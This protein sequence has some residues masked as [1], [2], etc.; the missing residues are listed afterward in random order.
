MINV[1]MGF[2]QVVIMSIFKTMYNPRFTGIHSSPK[3]RQLE[4]CCV[5]FGNDCIPTDCG[6]LRYT[7]NPT[8]CFKSAS[9]VFPIFQFGIIG[10]G[11]F[12]SPMGQDFKS[13][14]FMSQSQ[15]SKWV[16]QVDLQY[17]YTWYKRNTCKI[18]PLKMWCMHSDWSLVVNCMERHGALGGRGLLFVVKPYM[19]TITMS[20]RS[21]CIILFYQTFNFMFFSNR[22]ME[23]QKFKL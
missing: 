3:V 17:M 13:E 22:S 9:K 2:W 23:P 8:K 19:L 20:I 16:I 11:A 14:V 10:V 1:E 15:R 6:C 18:W 4:N 5:S 7:T 21:C 12:L